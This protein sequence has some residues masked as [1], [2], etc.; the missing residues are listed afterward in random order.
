M[1]YDQSEI[2]RCAEIEPEDGQA[3][4]SS[5]VSALSSHIYCRQMAGLSPSYQISANIRYL[6]QNKTT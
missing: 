1:T 6:E 3:A 4:S 5:I 2:D